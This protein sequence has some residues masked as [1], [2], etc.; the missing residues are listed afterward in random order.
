MCLFVNL[1][2]TGAKTPS[3]EAKGIYNLVTYILTQVRSKNSFHKIWAFKCNFEIF[4]ILNLQL[5]W[6]EFMINI[7][8]LKV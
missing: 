2:L 3:V 5:N 7:S 6:L 1:C 8:V 4:F